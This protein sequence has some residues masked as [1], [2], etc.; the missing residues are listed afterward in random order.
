MLSFKSVVSAVIGPR[1]RKPC[2]TAGAAQLK[3][4]IMLLI[5][6]LARKA[7]LNE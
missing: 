6:K 4:K 3:D 7:V 5:Q 2:L 1:F